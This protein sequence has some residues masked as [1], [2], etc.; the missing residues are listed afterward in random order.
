[1]PK[2]PQGQKRPADVTGNAPP[3]PQ[4]ALRINEVKDL[5]GGNFQVRLS[6][7]NRDNEITHTDIVC[8]DGCDAAIQKVKQDFAR[9]LK[10]VFALAAK[11]T[12]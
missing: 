12:A 7:G 8:A 2:R 9:W 1:M 4:S 3:I 6:I 11:R 5:G 10:K